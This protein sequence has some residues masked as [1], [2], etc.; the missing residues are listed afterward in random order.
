MWNSCHSS[1]HLSMHH[2]STDSDPKFCVTKMNQTGK[3][4]HRKGKPCLHSNYTI[5][6]A[7][8]NA[9]LSSCHSV[10]RPCKL[11]KM[12]TQRNRET[13]TKNKH[14]YRLFKYKHDRIQKTPW[15][16]IIITI[17]SEAELTKRVCRNYCSWTHWSTWERR[18]C[19][20]GREEGIW[21][22]CMTLWYC[23]EI[24]CCT[25]SVFLQLE[26]G[27]EQSIT[28][29]N[30]SVE[31]NAEGRSPQLGSGIQSTFHSLVSNNSRG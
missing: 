4:G 23:L 17:D 20:K 6:E 25:A 8:N 22:R 2:R 7:S 29:F 1:V 14:D 18:W 15:K 16:S 9:R 26:K 24:W 3:S 19:P 5:K 27:R 11:P 21:E 28:T 30:A 13:E 10:L 31:D 12:T